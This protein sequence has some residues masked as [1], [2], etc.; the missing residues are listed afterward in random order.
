[1]VIRSACERLLKWLTNSAVDQELCC[2]IRFR[3]CFDDAVFQSLMDTLLSAES[4]G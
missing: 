1:M 2:E 4:S 3:F